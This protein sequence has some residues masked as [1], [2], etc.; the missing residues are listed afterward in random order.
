[1]IAHVAM[2]VRIPYHY[3]MNCSVLCFVILQSSW[4]SEEEF[5]MGHVDLKPAAS[6]AKSLAANLV[7][8]PNGS[9]L[10]QTETAVLRNV[11]VGTQLIESSNSVKEQILRSKPV[12]G[13][14]ERSESSTLAKADSGQPKLKGG[15]LPNGADSISSSSTMTQPGTARPSGTQKNADELAKGHVDE[16]MPKIAPKGAVESEV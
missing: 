3:K 9:A 6:P 2:G 1:M 4:V 8:V 7:T 15:S 11:A 10:P 5:G 16:N 12:D 14:T 13:R